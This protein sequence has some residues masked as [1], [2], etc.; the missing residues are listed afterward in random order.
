MVKSTSKQVNGTCEDYEYKSC[1]FC[2]RDFPLYEDE[3][4]E[5]CSEYCRTM[6]KE[7]RER[8]PST[9]GQQINK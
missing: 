3:Q 6:D 8:F 4:K 9:D 1:G 2:T 7:M 5:H